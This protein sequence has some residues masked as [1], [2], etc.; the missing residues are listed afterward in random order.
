MLYILAR[1]YGA[2]FYTDPS[3]DVEAVQRRL[4]ADN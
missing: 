1:K 4:H 3:T 2:R